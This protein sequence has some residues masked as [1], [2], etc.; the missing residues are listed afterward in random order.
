MKPHSLGR[1]VF[2]VSG[3][4]SDIFLRPKTADAGIVPGRRFGA[5]R[6]DPARQFPASLLY[7]R[8][9]RIAVVGRIFK[10]HGQRALAL[11]VTGLTG[12]DSFLYR[13]VASLRRPRA[14][15]RR[16]NCRRRAKENSRRYDVSPYG[17]SQPMPTAGGQ[18]RCR[19]LP[20]II[21]RR[22][23]RRQ[24]EEAI[25]LRGRAVRQHPLRSI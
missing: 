11:T 23:D 24:A 10:D 4:S 13:S 8:E 1:T 9:T 15:T 14:A 6:I 25:R 19:V 18:C 22:R 12:V 2:K 7:A 20:W 3:R 16:R 21:L 5:S 17:A